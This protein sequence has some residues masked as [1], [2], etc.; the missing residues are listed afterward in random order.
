[1]RPLHHRMLL[2]L[3]CLL[4]LAEARAADP[5]PVTAPLEVLRTRHITVQVRI[6]DHGPFRLVLDTGSPVT[7]I[8]GRAAEK[9]GL[10]T[11]EAAGKPALL[12][13]RGRSTLK[14]VDV[15]G[16]RVA[17]MDALILDHP[18][19]D[20]LSQIEGPIDGIIGFSFFARFRTTIDYAAAKV[21]FTPVEYRPED[22]MTGLL[23]RVMNPEPV[24]RVVAAPGLWGMTVDKPDE[25]PGVRVTRVYPQSAAA[26]AGL[27]VGDRIT[28]VGG[29][30][31]ESVIDCFEAASRVKPGQASTLQVQRAGAE[32]ELMIRPRL[33]F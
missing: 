31:T 12:G 29:R 32:V 18:V 33:G 19:I 16:A 15:G 9:A 14:T 24:R 25:Q 11:A 7:F 28:A 6:N 3:L 30:W 27:R 13:M 5:R 4:P 20:Q 2:A 26:S 22:V 8:S 21:T 10:I 1:M 23:S 17:N